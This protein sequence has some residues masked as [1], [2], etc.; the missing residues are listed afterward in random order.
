MQSLN[1]YTY[2]LNS[3]LAFTDRTG[4]FCVSS[5]NTYDENG[6]EVAKVSLGCRGVGEWRLGFGVYAGN[7]FNNVQNGPIAEAYANHNVFLK[8]GATSSNTGPA[9]TKTGTVPKAK[10]QSCGFVSLTRTCAIQ[11]GVTELPHVGWSRGLREAA[12]VLADG[13]VVI[14]GYVIPKT[15]LI[16]IQRDI[17]QRSQA[18]DPETLPNEWGG[19]ITNIDGALSYTLHEG[20]VGF[21]EQDPIPQ[22]AIIQFHSHPPSNR[23][24]LNSL[25][26]YGSNYAS[27]NPA[28][29]TGLVRDIQ[30]WALYNLAARGVTGAIVFGPTEARAYDLRTITTTTPQSSGQV[31]LSGPEVF[32]PRHRCSGPT[33]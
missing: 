4:L 2:A 25:V 32:W 16:Q 13:S 33:C 30:G 5:S 28:I 7:S 8:A 21:V 29:L 14:G 10:A 1:L 22:G 12:A 6:D 26:Q 23:Y 9:T 17:A 19:Y 15:L 27:S 24:Q 31:V 18:T 20:T 11:T 3:P